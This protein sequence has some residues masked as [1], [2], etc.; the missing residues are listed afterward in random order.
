MTTTEHIE[1]AIVELTRAKIA[2]ETD[3]AYARA[4]LNDARMQIA[5]ALGELDNPTVHLR[6][7]RALE[8]EVA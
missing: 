5:G 6:A 2:V 1:Q 3:Y 7:R 8:K 4:R